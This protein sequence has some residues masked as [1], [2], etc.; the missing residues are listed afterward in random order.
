MVFFTTLLIESDNPDNLVKY[1]ITLKKDD[2]VIVVK[3]IKRNDKVDKKLGIST[4]DA[5]ILVEIKHSG[6]IKDIRHK[7]ANSGHVIS[8]DI[9][10]PYEYITKK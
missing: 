8:L 3:R 4:P 7:V 1:I 5:N 2:S 6:S 9:I 10:G